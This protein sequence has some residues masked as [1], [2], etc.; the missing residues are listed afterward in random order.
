MTP[1]AQTITGRALEFAAPVVEADHLFSE[2]AHG[3]SII[4]RFAGQTATAYS[5]AQHSV[6]MAEACEDEIDDPLVAAYCLLHDGHE[7]YLGDTPSPAKAAVEAEMLSAAAE[8]GVPD[9]IVE[10]QIARWRTLRRRIEQRLDTVIHRAAGLPPIDDRA[11]TLVKSYDVRALKTER[12]DLMTVPP[13][14][15][16]PAV[17]PA[18]PLALRQGRIRP[19]PAGIAAERFIGALNRLCP[20]AALAAGRLAEGDAA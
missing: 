15:W 4:A 7:A 18:Q 11:R 8:A 19:W 10:A 9:Q 2:V 14:P 1:W 16:D 13:R 3:L 20:N 5:V 6:L 17:E 12:R